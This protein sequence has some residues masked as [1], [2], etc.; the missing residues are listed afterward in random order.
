MR[1]L[2]EDVQQHTLQNFEISFNGSVKKDALF[3]KHQ[4]ARLRVSPSLTLLPILPK[5][6]YLQGQI[7]ARMGA[8]LLAFVMAVLLA[9]EPNAVSGI[10]KA[11]KQQYK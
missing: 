2:F 10:T 9:T 3:S 8:A 4:L 6:C 1:A 7:M 11:E 5:R